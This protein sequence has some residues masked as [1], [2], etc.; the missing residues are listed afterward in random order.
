M[1]SSQFVSAVLISVSRPGSPLPPS[2]RVDADA[3]DDHQAGQLDAGEDHVG[4]H[5]VGHADEVDQRQ[6][7]DERDRDDR[8]GRVG[9]LDVE[10]GRQVGGA[11][12]PGRGRRGRDAR[13]HDRERDHERQERFAERAVGVQR[14]AGRPR[15]LADELEVGERG[16]E[17]DDERHQRTAATARRR[18]SRRRCRSARR[19][20]CRGRPRSRRSTAVFGPMTRL[21]SGDFSS[22]EAVFS[23]TMP[24]ACP[25]MTAMTRSAR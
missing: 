6:Q 17:R 18:P 16:E 12:R 15:V 21:S 5:R 13:A 3:D 10:R 7:R 20:R 24:R 11:E 23:V 19:C 9:D 22:A 8:D 2:D 4:L 14:G 1:A 25:I